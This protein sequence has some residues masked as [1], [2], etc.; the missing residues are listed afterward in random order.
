M[1]GLQRGVGGLISNSVSSVAKT[2][3]PAF[4]LVADKRTLRLIGELA[5]ILGQIELSMRSCL[6]G[7]LGI[8]EHVARRM[9]GSSKHADNAQLWIEVMRSECHDTQLLEIAEVALKLFEPL[10]RGRNDFMHSVFGYESHGK[11]YLQ[12]PGYVPLPARG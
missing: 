1:P 11:V 8:P 6:I 9:L 12:H 10:M 4:A 7:L 2:S 5:V 3:K